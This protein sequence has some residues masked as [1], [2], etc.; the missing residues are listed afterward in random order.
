MSGQLNPPTAR[1][2]LGRVVS[3]ARYTAVRA[4]RTV[5]AGVPA[6]VVALALAPA[7]DAFVYWASP[8]GLSPISRANLDGSGV[9]SAFV[10]GAEATGSGLAVDG[11]HLYWD[12]YS[13]PTTIGYGNLDGTT[14]GGLIA[15]NL[16]SPGACGVAVGGGHIYWAS[17]STI[18]RANLNGT[19]VEPNFITNLT[20]PCGVAVDSAHIYWTN[21][22][23]PPGGTTIGRANLDG[24]GVNPSFISGLTAAMRIAVDGSHVYWTTWN[25]DT[26]GRANLNGTGIADSFISGLPGDSESCGIAVD[27]EHIYWREVEHFIGGDKIAR[28]NLDGSHVN[29]SFVTTEGAATGENCSL[30]VDALWPASTSLTPS[31]ATI[32]YGEALSFKAVVASADVGGASATP[33]GTVSFTVTGEPPEQVQLSGTGLAIFDPGYY[34]N[35]GDKVSARYSGNATYGPRRVELVP[36][37]QPAHTETALTMSPN[38]Q[39]AAGD[40]EINATVTNSSTNVIPFGSVQFA[41][42][43]EALGEPQS[44]DNAGRTGIIV[45][46]LKAGQHTVTAYYYDGGEPTPDFTGSKAS[47]T[48]RITGPAPPPPPLPPPPPP[49]FQATLSAF[50]RVLGIGDLLRG[51][52]GDSVVLTGPGSVTEDLFE[53]NGVVPAVATRASGARQNKHRRRRPAL[54]LARGSASTGAAGAVKV[55]LLP[56]RAGKKTLKKSRH[57][58]QVVL[59]TSVKDAKTGKVTTLGTQKL[60]LKR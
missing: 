5:L 1:K 46:G 17:G 57:G 21:S 53:A 23:F 32:T 11:T 49:P 3:R 8:G 12:S 18:G 20:T 36:S 33:T 31:Q 27:G 41:I 38:P 35:A 6:V 39:S 29:L 40:V 28:A 37:I 24:T 47:L 4:R 54:L 50:P 15:L 59:I 16:Q 13:G 56:T 52:F 45:S 44:L 34:L 42:D 30:A 2:G 22:Q 25:N 43:E 7:A 48:E 19:E 26:I 55:T 9:E 58:M 60:T 51:R 10:F 14:E